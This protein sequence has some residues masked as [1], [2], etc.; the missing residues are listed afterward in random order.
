M[1]AESVVSSWGGS[2]CGGA[3]L[4][5]PAEL[6]G[7]E[8]RVPAE[9]V[10]GWGGM[11]FRCICREM[12]CCEAVTPRGGSR[13]LGATAAATGRGQ[14]GREL[15]SCILALPML[16]KATDA[17]PGVSRGVGPDGWPDG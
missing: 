8:P 5:A 1:G 6:V 2:G 9:A 11:H 3:K 13:V 16:L 7:L 15:P 14:R 10:D 4:P 12:A 17:T